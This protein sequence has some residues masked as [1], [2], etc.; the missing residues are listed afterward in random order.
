MAASYRV[1]FGAMDEG[2]LLA[3]KAFVD[4][5]RLRLLGALS[6]RPATADDLATRLGLPRA[7]LERNLAMLA[8]GGLLRTSEEGR[9][10]LD[11][12]RVNGLGR[13]LDSLEPTAREEASLTGPDGRPL[14][15]EDAKILRGYL[16]GDRL[17]EIPAQQR[18]RL[19]VL[20]YLRDRCF[21]E[22]RLY[23]EKEVNQ[24]LGLFHRDVAS[25]RR[26]LVDSG[27]M[28]RA[29]GEYRRVPD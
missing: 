24:R 26:Y 4:P 5:V 27:L 25:L 22:D 21:T 2:D 11:L 29:A 1:A 20:R 28:I 7:R 16:D 17:R 10:E 14:P 12:A 8:R 15:A 23:P 13:L 18:K 6:E 9:Y 19:V 3:L